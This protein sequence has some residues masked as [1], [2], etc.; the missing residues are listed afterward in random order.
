LPGPP[1]TAALALVEAAD[2]AA[3]PGIS[4]GVGRPPRRACVRA[5]CP[6]GNRG[7]L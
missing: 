5:P 6:L 4:P 2:P 7:I 3:R 1:G